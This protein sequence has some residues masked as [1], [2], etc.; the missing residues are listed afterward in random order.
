MSF[1][2]GATGSTGGNAELGPELP[3]LFTDVRRVD[4]L[5]LYRLIAN[6]Y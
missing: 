6:T 5:P 4:T 2:F 1:G 3:D